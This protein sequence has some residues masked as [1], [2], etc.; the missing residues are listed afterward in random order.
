[1]NQIA[2][3]PSDDESLT[4]ELIDLYD[5]LTEKIGAY[6]D[7]STIPALL[8]SMGLEDPYDVYF[9]VI[10][11]IESFSQ[12]IT[13]P[14]LLD[15]VK[16]GHNGSK[17]WAVFMLGRTRNPE[18]IPYL[19]PVLENKVKEVR[20]EAV[21]ALG[22]IAQTSNKKLLQRFRNLA[23]EALKKV[24]LTDSS[25]RV[26]RYAEESLSDYLSV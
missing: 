11:I 26:R 21:S 4:P 8:R 2:P 1:M 12:D 23:M 19:I 10:H 15:A 16:T 6:H 25:S 20:I 17:A 3:L 13:F 14:F 18:A 7:P 24:K 9:S 5:D 22:M